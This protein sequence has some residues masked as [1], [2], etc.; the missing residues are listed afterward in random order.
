[1]LCANSCSQVIYKREMMKET[2]AKDCES[3]EKKMASI[4]SD[5]ERTTKSERETCERVK[6]E[7]PQGLEEAKK[8][9]QQG[10]KEEL[11]KRDQNMSPKLKRDAAKA[12]EPKSSSTVN[13]PSTVTTSLRS[14]GSTVIAFPR[15]ATLNKSNTK[16]KVP[17]AGT[18]D[19]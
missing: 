17:L 8:S 2:L 5:I 16:S 7:G 9:W 6:R 13:T 11:K 10:E 3:L 19:S 18:P 15:V 4:Q 1:M 14:I 12:V